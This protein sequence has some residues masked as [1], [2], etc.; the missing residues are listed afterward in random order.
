MIPKTE[1]DFRNANYEYIETEGQDI[2]PEGVGWEFWSMRITSEE[3]KAVW[4]RSVT[5]S[6]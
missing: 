5:L 3:S 4:V 1:E 2:V 6:E